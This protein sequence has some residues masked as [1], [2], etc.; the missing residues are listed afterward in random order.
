[1]VCSLNGFFQPCLPDWFQQIIN[2]IQFVAVEGKLWLGGRK[3]QQR[4]VIERTGKIKSVELG[5]LDIQH[6]QVHGV[7]QQNITGLTGIAGRV[8]QCPSGQ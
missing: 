1:M 6:K 8:Q 7:G 3:N 5:H 4:S 2:G